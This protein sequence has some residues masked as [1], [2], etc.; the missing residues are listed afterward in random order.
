MKWINS[1]Y[2]IMVGAPG[3]R[4]HPHK[5]LGSNNFSLTPPTTIFCTT[6]FQYSPLSVIP[7][8]WDFSIGWYWLGPICGASY[9]SPV[10]SLEENFARV[11]ALW[12]YRL[13]LSSQ[14]GIRGVVDWGHFST[15][16][17]KSGAGLRHKIWISEMTHWNDWARNYNPELSK[18]SWWH[19]PT[20]VCLNW[21]LEDLRQKW[22]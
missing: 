2:W 10:L 6:V 19:C 5:L 16:M 21:C 14:L 8:A 15:V 12:T 3:C 1:Y 18:W 11:S 17:D 7:C 13:P 22:S 9:Q 20:C 4:L